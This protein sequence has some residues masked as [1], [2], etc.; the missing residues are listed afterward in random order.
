MGEKFLRKSDIVI[1]VATEKSSPNLAIT[2]TMA[3]VLSPAASLRLKPLSAARFL[4]FYRKTTVS[5]PVLC[6]CVKLPALYSNS[7]CL[8][9]RPRSF[10][11]IISAAL[12]SGEATKNETFEDKEAKLG[13]KVGEFRKRLRIVDIKSGPDEGLNRLGDTLAIRGWVRTLRIQSS[14][15]F[16]E[17]FFRIY[18]TSYVI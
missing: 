8:H 13:D 15:T 5:V 10:C 17:V 6:P 9:P 1:A 2:E 7:F 18:D 11:S 3:A 16:I 12:S 14:V 4:A